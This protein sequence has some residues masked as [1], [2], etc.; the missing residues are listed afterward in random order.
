LDGRVSCDAPLP[1]RILEAIDP[2]TSKGRRPRPSF[3]LGVG[4][5]KTFAT[6]TTDRVR[7]F[8]FALV[9]L[10][11]LLSEEEGFHRGFSNRTAGISRVFFQEI[12]Q[13]C[14]VSHVAHATSVAMLATMLRSAPLQSDSA[15]TASSLVTNPTSAP[16]PEPLRPSNATIAR[17]LVTF[18]QTAQLCD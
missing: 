12:Q 3:H 18:R 5:R 9:V 1:F 11:G 8:H 7:A 10:G 16:C 17:V 15:T 14:R 2:F 13:E 4:S 6:F